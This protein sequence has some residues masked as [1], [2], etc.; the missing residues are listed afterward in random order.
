VNDFDYYGKLG[1]GGFGFVVHCK[2]KS[3]GGHYAM[4][5]QTK[6]GLLDCYHDEPQKVSLEKD[7]FASLQ[8][9]FIVNLHYAFQT[10]ALVMMV[11]DL[12]DCGDLNSCLN[13]SFNG[14]LSEDRVRF[15]LAEII[16]ALAYLHQRGLIYRDLK[17]QNVLLNADG[18]VQ[19]VDLGGVM[20]DEGTWTEKVKNE[21]HSL[22]PLF[23]AQ[24]AAMEAVNAINTSTSTNSSKPP[25]T[26]ETAMTEN[27]ELVTPQASPV[28][29]VDTNQEHEPATDPAAATALDSP[30]PAEVQIGHDEACKE[31]VVI[32]K[33]KKVAAK[34]RQSI[35]GTLGYMA[36]EMVIM[37]S[38]SMPMYPRARNTANNQDRAATKKLMRKGYTSAVDWWSLGVTAFKLLTGNR[39]FADQ[40]MMAFV[41]MATTT[42][43]AAVGENAHFKEY[44][45]LFQ[46]LSFPSHVSPVAKD[47]IT[48]LLDV[49]DTT[50]LGAGP[51]GVSNIKRHPFFQGLDWELLEQKQIPPPF[52][53]PHSA[54]K[55]PL[56]EKDLR[57]LL[58]LS[59]KGHYMDQVLGPE[60]QKHFETWDFISPHTLRVEAGLSQMME[61]LVL[62][63]KA[64]RIM[65]ESDKS[66]GM[67]RPAQISDKHFHGSAAVSTQPTPA[68]GRSNKPM[69]W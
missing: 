69:V 45:M 41:D 20:D 10:P 21:Y 53:P 64:R 52:V 5:I 40:Q 3:T 42:L 38:S 62:N 19:L 37:L 8:H 11:L 31:V 48:A 9:P 6:T 57:S 29:A 23:S 46:K 35:M 43:H 27:G 60:D 2:K 16:L 66:D 33:P 58:I 59:G 34:R 26:A 17:P 67:M 24:K 54:L 18:H 44:S 55:G 1:E 63:Q 30:V 47:F 56:M 39:P 4:K 49:S 61:Q 65:G 50:R 7:A 12:A 32:P 68:G 13:N 28:I 36:P 51:D 22:M 25:T 15:Y 14:R